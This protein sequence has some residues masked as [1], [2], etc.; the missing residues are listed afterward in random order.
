MKLTNKCKEDFEKWLIMNQNSQIEQDKY[1]CSRANLGEMKIFNQLPNSMKYGVL[2]DFFD[3]V[4][5][6]ISDN[7]EEFTDH[8]KSGLSVIVKNYFAWV[9]ELLIPN[10]KTR[11]QARIKAIEQANKIYNETK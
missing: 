6:Y 1:D 5:I 11:N 7:H 8:D 3:S 4:G 9:N 2:V 10:L